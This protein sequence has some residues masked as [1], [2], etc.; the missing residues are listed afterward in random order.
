MVAFYIP[1]YEVGG[2]HVSFK[3]GHP[4]QHKQLPWSG[5]PRGGKK[6]SR[7]RRDAPS[8]SPNVL[9]VHGATHERE[10][11]PDPPSPYDGEDHTRAL[12]QVGASVGADRCGIPRSV[13]E[14]AA[15]IE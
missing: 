8:A 3:E 1:G 11:R 4:D 10:G 5:A 2:L 6:G 12:H 7:G 14:V 15:K 13:L 9:N